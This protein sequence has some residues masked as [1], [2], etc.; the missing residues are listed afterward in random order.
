MNRKYILNALAFTLCLSTLQPALMA[1]DTQTVVE[2]VVQTEEQPATY[3]EAFMLRIKNIWQHRITQEMCNGAIAIGCVYLCGRVVLHMREESSRREYNIWHGGDKKTS[4]K[5]SVKPFSGKGVKLGSSTDAKT[6][7]DAEKLYA[8]QRKNFN[9]QAP[10]TTN[11][12]GPAAKPTPYKPYAVHTVG[13][14]ATDT[15]Q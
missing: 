12:N 14:C 3:T 8:S 1:G 10:Q 15:A 5:S 6:I 11:S 13:S 4:Q 9:T 7:L 2:N